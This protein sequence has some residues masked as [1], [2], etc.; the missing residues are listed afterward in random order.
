MTSTCPPDSHIQS[1]DERQTVSGLFI[2][3][4]GR[5]CRCTGAFFSSI[6]RTLNHLL[7]T[8]TIWLKRIQQAVLQTLAELDM[9][10]R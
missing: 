2:L 1:V 6:L 4:P 3:K 10:V 7:V 5:A 9:P 8:D